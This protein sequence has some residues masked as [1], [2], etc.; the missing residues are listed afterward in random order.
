MLL[1]PLALVTSPARAEGTVS[2]FAT[3][4]DNPR[5]LKFGPD[6]ALYVAEGGPGGSN[7]TVGQ[8]E[9]VVEPVGPYTGGSGARIS[10]VN[11]AGARTT[12]VGDLPSS[13]TSAAIGG[14]VGGV[15]DVAFVGD[16]LYGVLAGA[17][18]SHGV[19]DVSNVVFRVNSDGSWTSVADMT[20]FYR[21]NPVANP[22][23][24][25]FE[26]DGGPY[27][28]I[29][30]DGALYV[31]EPN[32]GTLDRVTTDGQIS[33]IV[34]ISASQGHTVPT[35]IVHRDGAFY[36][37][38][39]LPFPP[40]ELGLASVLRVTP[41]GDVSVFATGL[42]T[43]VG[44]D[45]DAQGRMYVLE[46]IATAGPMPTPGSGRVLR[47]TA[48]GA[49]EVVADGLTFP[50]AMTFGPDGML[51]VSNFGFGFPP[52]QGQV[53]RINVAPAPAP[54]IP[55]APAAP[56]PAGPGPAVPAAPVQAPAPQVPRG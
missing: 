39:L 20:A 13:Q 17:A 19:P 35:G 37:G 43:A 29:E 9:Q 16:T 48:G 11:S 21:A 34:D 12:V 8:C 51:Y 18:C 45:F 44:V 32:H 38:T 30:V 10:K 7:S 23:P 31:V 47:L 49:S 15:A 50:T 2:V 46:S 3:G 36:L 4:L 5:G 40:A 24:A 54:A 1:V 28:M 56:A 33:R 41:T 26:P 14:L 6:G 27:S 53:V 42:N 55:A 22:Q 52:G 25:D